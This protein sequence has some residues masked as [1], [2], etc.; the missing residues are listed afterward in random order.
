[1]T[2]L[3]STVMPLSWVAKQ[4]KLTLHFN[5]TYASRLNKVESWFSAFTRVVVKNFFGA[6]SRC[7]SSRQQNISDST[8]EDEHI[9]YRLRCEIKSLQAYIYKFAE[10]NKC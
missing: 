5:Q 10:H 2:G 1:V 7:E 9:A 3:I 6:Q 4:S 8:I